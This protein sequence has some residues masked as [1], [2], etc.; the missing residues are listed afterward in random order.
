MTKCLISEQ[1]SK[2]LL[3]GLLIAGGLFKSSHDP[4]AFCVC[5]C[6]RSCGLNAVTYFATAPAAGQLFPAAK[7]EP[8]RLEQVA[9]NGNLNGNNYRRPTTTTTTCQVNETFAALLKILACTTQS[10]TWSWTG[11]RSSPGRRLWSTKTFW[12]TLTTWP[13][14]V[15]RTALGC[16]RISSSWRIYFY[17]PLRWLHVDVFCGFFGAI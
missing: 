13:A 3:Y 10:D 4:W 14:E 12:P 17:L 1:E 7:G 6:L 16:A 5:C 8:F 9:F 11:T 2:K 15:A